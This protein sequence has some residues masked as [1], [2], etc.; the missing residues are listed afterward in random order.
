LYLGAK[1][2]F[3]DLLS[4]RLNSP[5]SIGR[6]GAIQPSKIGPTDTSCCGGEGNMP[7]DYTQRFQW[8]AMTPEAG[9][10]PSSVSDER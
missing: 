7:W 6:T 10:G 3:G 2:V 8:D 9:T 5:A 4:S 1:H